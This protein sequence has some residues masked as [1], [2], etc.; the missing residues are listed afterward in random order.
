MPERKDESDRRPFVYISCGGREIKALI[1]SGAECNVIAPGLLDVPIKNSTTTMRGPDGAPMRNR[2]TQEIN[3][4]VAGVTF[5]EDFQVLENSTQPIILGSKFLRNQA[6]VM[7]YGRGC[8]YIGTSPRKCV[9]WTQSEVP[10]P[11]RL[12]MNSLISF[13]NPYTMHF[14][15]WCAT[16]TAYS[17]KRDAPRQPAVCAI[18]SDLKG[19]PRSNSDHGSI[20]QR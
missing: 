19:T 9:Y 10:N 1:D 2:G 3:F 15:H 6:A 11:P 16:I 14:G 7:D 17:P 12:R 8:M 4:K 18:E 20:A 5:R 13:P